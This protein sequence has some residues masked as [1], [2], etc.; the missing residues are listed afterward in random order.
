MQLITNSL[1]DNASK[2][3]VNTLAANLAVLQAT[4]FNTARVRHALKNLCFYPTGIPILKALLDLLEKELQSQTTCFKLLCFHIIRHSR[5]G[6]DVPASPEVLAE[7]ARQVTMFKKPPK[8]PL[9]L[10]R[11][12]FHLSRF[13]SIGER[14]LV[15]A[16]VAIF[17]HDPSSSGE[18]KRRSTI[19]STDLKLLFEAIDLCLDAESYLLGQVIYDVDVQHS[20]ANLY[21]HFPQDNRRQFVRILGVLPAAPN[22]LVEMLANDDF[23][24]HSPFAVDY[25]VAN[26]AP[27]AALLQSRLETPASDTLSLLQLRLLEKE[28]PTE[29]LLESISRGLVENRTFA[30]VLPLLN[31]L[32]IRPFGA[33]HAGALRS[34]YV[35][36]GDVNDLLAFHAVLCLALFT[37]EHQWIAKSMRQLLSAA[38]FTRRR[39][40]IQIAV[41]GF[42]RALASP[43]VLPMFWT[44]VDLLLGKFEQ[45]VDPVTFSALVKKLVEGGRG[46]ELLQHAQ[47][48]LKGLPLVESAVILFHA[49]SV[50]RA[51]ASSEANAAFMKFVRSYIESAGPL[52]ISFYNT[53]LNSD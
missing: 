49:A 33:I 32:V 4:P 16:L 44:M 42:T 9:L 2:Q 50:A 25:L 37:D 13:S 8:N 17:T 30:T 18:K 31:F 36:A 41:R 40:L 3:G 38:T 5:F 22:R 1:A 29:R 23:F 46:D 20:I 28:G 43:A 21:P 52:L 27:Y 6:R 47:Q 51:A 11:V 14:T 35:A 26:D 34:L 24:G 12:L 15:K 19:R 45:A 10:L 7:L 48:I 39:A 53:A